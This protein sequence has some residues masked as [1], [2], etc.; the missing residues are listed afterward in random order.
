MKT[1]PFLQNLPKRLRRLRRWRQP[2][3]PPIPTK[4]E[5]DRDELHTVPVWLGAQL[6][7][8]PMLLKRGKRRVTLYDEWD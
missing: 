2:A 7:P 5:N 8:F 3:P 4:A 1:L 6:T